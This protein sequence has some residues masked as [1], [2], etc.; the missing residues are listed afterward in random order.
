MGQAG[1]KPHRLEGQ[2]VNWISWG[3]GGLGGTYRALAAEHNAPPR[4]VSVT[5][6]QM[7]ALST[8]FVIF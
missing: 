5:R 8:G 7:S 1:S 6:L 3:A 2:T 4:G